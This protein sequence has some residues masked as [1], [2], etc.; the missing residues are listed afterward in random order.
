MLLFS[1]MNNLECIYQFFLSILFLFINFILF[2]FDIRF[3]I[4]GGFIG[5]LSEMF[6]FGHF[7]TTYLND[8]IT[9]PII[10]TIFLKGLSIYTGVDLH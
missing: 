8:N 2:F 3:V 4:G 5:G 6:L 7:M 9:I 1:Q 10:C